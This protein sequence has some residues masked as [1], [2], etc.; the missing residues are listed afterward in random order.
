MTFDQHYGE[1]NIERVL[2]NIDVKR[3]S[4]VSVCIK[5]T[6]AKNVERK[7][8]EANCKTS[9]SACGVMG[10]IGIKM[11][12]LK[13]CTDDWIRKNHNCNGR[14]HRKNC[15]PANTRRCPISKTRF[16]SSP[17]TPNQFRNK[18]CGNRN[19][20][21]AVG[22]HEECKSFAVRILVATAGFGKVL[23]EDK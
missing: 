7:A 4:S 14:R 11:S 10:G 12:V 16:I 21:Q 22:E 17:N 18:S 19:C 5:A 1:G 13:K 8:R 9:Q 15:D 3:C 2:K 6:Q 20:Q 23:N